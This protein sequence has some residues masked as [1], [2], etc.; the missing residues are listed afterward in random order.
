[1]A[2][3]DRVMTIEALLASVEQRRRLLPADGPSVP[4]GTWLLVS[5]LDARMN[6]NTVV[7]SVPVVDPSAHPAEILADWLDAGAPGLAA[8]AAAC[9]WEGQFEEV[10]PGAPPLLGELRERGFVAALDAL[11][12]RSTSFYDRV[13]AEPETVRD[14]F[15]DA[16]LG[17]DRH[18][19]RFF[20]VDVA[21]LAG[22]FEY[23]DHLGNDHCL[24]WCDA[25]SMRV[26]FTNGSD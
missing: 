12:T 26:L 18:R 17:P 11:L 7:S 24:L 13:V 25:R 9:D 1:M 6:S 2:A 22:R 5:A 8:A 23:F 21:S 15:L 3:G 14:R 16:E 4:L 19:W 20:A 10:R